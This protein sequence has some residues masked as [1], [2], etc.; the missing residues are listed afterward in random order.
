MRKSFS[1]LLSI[2]FM[3]VMAV[4]GVMVMEFSASTSH[5]ASESFLD[6]KANLALRSATEYAILAIQGHDFK[7]GLINEI[8]ISYP[9]FNANVKIHYFLTSCPSGSGNDCT[10]IHTADTNG[11]L[12]LYTTVTSKNSSFRI[13]K[14]K[15]TLQNP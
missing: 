15:I 12:I 7:N 8:N 9:L 1:L 14:V 5:H 2:I 4:I 11:T 3:I 13:R 10:Q 6:T